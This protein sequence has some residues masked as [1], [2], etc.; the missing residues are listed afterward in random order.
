MTDQAGV[1]AGAQQ[2]GGFWIRFLAYVTDSAILFIASSVVI[3]AATFLGDAGAFAGALMVFLLA[4]LYWPLMQASA[5]QATFGK[6]L[7]G[8]KVA[9]GSTG[10]RISILRSFG[11]ELGKIVSSAVFS[12]GFIIAGFTR[13]KQALHDLMALTVVVREAPARIVAALAVSVAA[14]VLPIVAVPMLIGGAM[15]GMLMSAM[16]DLQHCQVRAAPAARAPGP[17]PP[18]PPPG[19]AAAVR[20]GGVPQPVAAAPQPAPEPKPIAPEP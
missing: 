11:R 18:P 5:R 7:L 3:V 20:A 16:G 1:G 8:L 6:Q 14:I 15:V 12:L 13:R 4:L 2:Y 10:E 17:P 19:T 9:H